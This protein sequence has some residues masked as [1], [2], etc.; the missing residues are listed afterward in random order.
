MTDKPPFFS[1]ILPVY[2]R[3]NL[4]GRALQSCLTQTFTDF[5]VVV[6][7]DGSTDSSVEV[8]L[9]LGDPRIRVLVHTSNRG[10]CPAR[11][12]AMSASRGQW[13]VFLDSD[14]ELLPDALD[15]IYADAVA[16]PADVT[17]LRYSCVNEQG[18]ISPDPPY[19]HEMWTYERYLR[20]IEQSLQGTSET[21]PCS[22]ASTFPEVAYPDSHAEEGLYHLDLARRGRVVV[23]SAVVRRYYGDAPNQV[24]SPNVRRSMRYA[25]DAARNVDAILAGHGETLRKYA[26]TVFALRLQEGALYYFMSGQRASGLDYARRHIR[27]RGVSLKLALIVALGMA[28]GLPLAVSQG[29]QALLRRPRDE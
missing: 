4:V 14:D 8:A 2:N 29:L 27:L 28:G 7:D 12:T 25:P 16:A 1:V 18:S 3:S 20:W 17:A 6:A 23:S 10:R 21:L 26:P 24:T 13:F 5:E 19:P 11:N 22:R 15:T 9:S